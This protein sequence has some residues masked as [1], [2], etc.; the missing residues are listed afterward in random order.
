[1]TFQIYFISSTH[2]ACF[3]INYSTK[4]VVLYIASITVE[5]LSFYGSIWKSLIWKI[6]VKTYFIQKGIQTTVIIKN[7]ASGKTMAMKNN[8]MS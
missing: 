2:G 3:R 1:M 6:S 4:D 8:I 7:G 5:H